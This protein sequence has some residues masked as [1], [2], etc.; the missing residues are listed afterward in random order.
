M[1]K[2]ENTFHSFLIYIYKMKLFI[3]PTRSNALYAPFSARRRSLQT[4][5]VSI[6]WKSSSTRNN[7]STTV[8]HAFDS[9]LELRDFVDLYIRLGYPFMTLILFL[10][11]FRQMQIKHASSFSISQRPIKNYDNYDWRNVLSTD[12]QAS[13]FVI[14]M[15]KLSPV[16]CTFRLTLATYQI[17]FRKL[18]E[19]FLQCSTN[20]KYFLNL[21]LHRLFRLCLHIY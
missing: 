9:Q 7:I 21:N 11:K 1:H 10:T 19:L 18:L 14:I 8:E 16:S 4:R 20:C 2:Q 17:C 15:H 13:Y 6:H 12:V 3:F 5:F